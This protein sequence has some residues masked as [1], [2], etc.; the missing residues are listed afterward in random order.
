MYQWAVVSAVETNKENKNRVCEHIGVSQ[1]KN[2]ACV[3]RTFP[4]PLTK[5][6][7]AEASSAVAV[8][9]ME[10]LELADTPVVST[11]STST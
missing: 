5:V 6:F 7:I 3:Q 8:A 2:E 10:A 11:W 4:P 1:I 9:V